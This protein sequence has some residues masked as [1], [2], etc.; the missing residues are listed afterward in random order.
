MDFCN[1]AHVTI[2]KYD[3]FTDVAKYKLNKVPLWAWIKGMLDGLTAKKELAEK[4]AAKMGNH[5]SRSLLMKA[6]STRRAL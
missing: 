6:K 2:Q 3:G 4:V 5:R 1:S